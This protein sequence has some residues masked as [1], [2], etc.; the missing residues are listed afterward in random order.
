MND[1]MITAIFTLLGVIIGGIISTVVSFYTT[2]KIIKAELKKQRI[3]LLSQK[4]E[5]LE[6]ELIKIYV[7]DS[8]YTNENNIRKSFNILSMNSHYFDQY[9]FS[10]IKNE[11]WDLLYIMS[12]DNIEKAMN[13]DYSAVLPNDESFIIQC[14]EF[15][16][17][18]RNIFSVEIIN[19]TKEINKSLTV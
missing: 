3:I 16:N 14:A 17:K 15:I 1:A 4:K 5:K 6:N 7:N 10:L 13:G 18:N 9:S 2:K 11:Y 12:N 19:T 8:E